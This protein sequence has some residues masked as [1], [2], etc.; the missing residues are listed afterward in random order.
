LCPLC[1]KISNG[2][3]P[4]T[5]EVT[6]HKGSS[7]RK[8]TLDWIS[9]YTGQQT[10][11][12]QQVI[13][14]SKKNQNAS[15]RSFSQRLMDI[16]VKTPSETNPFKLMTQT[17]INTISSAELL[18]RDV[19]EISFHYELLNDRI[20]DQIRQLILAGFSMNH[21]PA[22]DLPRWDILET[23]WSVL[24][25][26]KLMRPTT[27]LRIQDVN[28]S[29]TSSEETPSTTSQ[30]LGDGQSTTPS[31]QISTSPLD[32]DAFTIWATIMMS[33][34]VLFDYQAPSDEFVS[35]LTKVMLRLVGAQ[36]NDPKLE[37][38]SCL[39]FLRKVLLF[40]KCWQVNNNDHIRNIGKKL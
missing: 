10:G 12:S 16:N 7:L 14:I 26:C 15:Y 39:P 21:E 18:L 6:Q 22:R 2:L 40:K 19:D 38:S 5:W 37:H 24:F 23:Y 3:I 9:V 20:L 8:S 29:M 27:A 25:D 33:S 36:S 28:H 34:P 17:L 13:E 31:V 4:H 35:H 32:L 11:P 30:P 1:R